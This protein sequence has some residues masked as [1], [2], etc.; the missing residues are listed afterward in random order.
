MP[1]WSDRKT[2]LKNS[3]RKT[4]M[5][6]C[7]QKVIGETI[8]GSITKNGGHR[9]TKDRWNDIYLNAIIILMKIIRLETSSDFYIGI[10]VT[11]E[12]RSVKKVLGAPICQE[13]NITHSYLG[14]RIYAY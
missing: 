9:P 3:D 6:T 7:T 4:L 13:N 11:I 2:G 1:K 10:R 14:G 12:W 5:E 8:I